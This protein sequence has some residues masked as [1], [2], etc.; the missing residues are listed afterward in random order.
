ML[1][2]RARNRRSEDSGSCE[3]LLVGA[4]EGL[5][6]SSGAWSD[7][8]AP[9]RSGTNQR[10]EAVVTRGLA[11][12]T[13]SAVSRSVA[14]RLHP[15]GCPKGMCAR[16]SARTTVA[17]PSMPDGV[18]ACQLTGL[19][20]FQDRFVSGRYKTLLAAISWFKYGPGMH[21]RTLRRPARYPLV[22][23]PNER[24]ARRSCLAA[25]RLRDLFA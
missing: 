2:G 17:I 3:L 18:D 13:C 14:L 7:P 9:S 5:L 25:G 21:V 15:I 22:G 4:P 23:L 8:R 24:R 1:R 12:R 20:A 16:V 19:H 10:V 11:I 6:R